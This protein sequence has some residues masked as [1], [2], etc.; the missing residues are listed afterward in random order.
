MEAIT[1]FFALLYHKSVDISS[2]F[3]PN[4]AEGVSVCAK[5]N[6]I[7][8]KHHI[9]GRKPTSFEAKP[10]HRSFVP[11]GGNDVELMLK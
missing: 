9:I 4:H 8:A 3:A 1:P 5:R 11:R 7:D 10:Q 2:A 6:I